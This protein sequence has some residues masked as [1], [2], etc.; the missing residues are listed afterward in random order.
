MSDGEKRTRGPTRP[1][2][3]R[4]A[5]IKRKVQ[6]LEKS[7]S[8]AGQKAFARARILVGLAALDRAETDPA[9]AVTMAE[10]LRS[11]TKTDRD[12]ASVADLLADLDRFA[13]SAASPRK[14]FG[15]F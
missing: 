5:E 1:V 10:A 12:R 13:A 8:R 6:R 11:F 9:F 3:Q 14:R 2:D 7:Q 15:I 4:L